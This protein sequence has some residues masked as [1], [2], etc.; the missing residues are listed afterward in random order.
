MKRYGVFISHRHED[1]MLAGRVFDI[2]ESRGFQ[3]FLDADS[4]RQG[5][6]HKTLEK[7]VQETPYFLCLLTK[8]TFQ[9]M[10]PEDWIYKE[11]KTALE[12][13]R[14][15]LLL[16]ER[17]FVFP[18]EL[19]E[20]IEVI[21]RYH[22]YEFDRTNFLD[23][24]N[25]ICQRDIKKELLTDVLDWKNSLKVR[26]TTCLYPRKQI[27][28]EIAPLEDRFGVERVRCI[29]E[30][31]PYTGANHIQFVHMSCYAA[32]IIFSHEV[33]MVDEQAF[34]RGLMF[35]IFANLLEDEEFSLELIINAPGSFAVSDAIDNK[36][37]G[38]SALEAYPEA[39]FLSAYCN[40]RRL[41]KEDPVFTK[42]YQDKRFR[43][44]V[45][46]SVLP[47]ALFQ[48]EYNPGFEEYS[49]IKV[50]L[51]S[52]G[53]VSNMDRRCMMIFK[54]DDPENYS[55]FAERYKFI[56]NV[57]ESRRLITA[58]HE[59]WLQEWADMQEELNE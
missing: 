15:I 22:C 59:R 28:R 58:N 47:Y 34:D 35:N 49:H 41:I 19:P 37:L 27:E 6:F 57:R 39:I 26:G 36:K 54:E 20:E 52:E 43:F 5:D 30:G 3:P 21:S 14:E 4:M 11:I 13:S 53:L 51:Y 46:E 45:T 17:G 31:K 56:R 29:K 1:W 50:D 18:T 16:A 24:L 48:M 25:R 33:D 7:H 38:N 10:D 9:T 8:Y 40:I 55:F 2:L 44:M 32:S 23:V 42:A 12:S